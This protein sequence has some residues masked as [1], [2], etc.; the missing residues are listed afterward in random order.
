[1]KSIE[2]MVD[3]HEYIKRM[4]VVLRKYS[5]KVVKGEDVDINDF[6]LMIDFVRS[7]AD[8]HHHSKEE[9]FLF[10]TMME[11]QGPV[12]EKLIRHGMLVEHDLGRL[13]MMDLEAALKELESGNDEAK[14]DIIANAVGYA[15]LLARHIDKENNVVYP[16]A[17]KG[18]PEEVLKEVDDDCEEFE[19]NAQKEQVREKYIDILEKL[20]AKIG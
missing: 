10:K 11:H 18:L 13:H 8:K 17:E 15:S 7:F 19:I 9:E 20:E 16:F 6:Y 5:Y 1:M 3:E 4:L 12:A 14:I 2:L